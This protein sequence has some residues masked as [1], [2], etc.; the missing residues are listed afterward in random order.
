METTVNELLS[1]LEFFSEIFNIPPPWSND[2][3][4]WWHKVV[5]DIDTELLY[6]L[7]DNNVLGR[8]N[9]DDLIFMNNLLSDRINDLE[10]AI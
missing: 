1:V 8:Y 4:H 3:G 2:I 6:L 5:N 10:K 7:Y 9:N